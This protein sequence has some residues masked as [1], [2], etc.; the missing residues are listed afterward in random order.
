M[1]SAARITK[2][3]RRLMTTE[4]YLALPTDVERS[5]LIYG[6]VVVSPSAAWEHNVI[7]YYFRHILGC[8][9]RHFKLGQVC[10]DVDMVLDTVRHLIYQPDLVYLVAKHAARRDKGR[11]YGAADLCVEVQSPSDRPWIQNRKF[12]DYE[13]YGVSWYWIIR[14]DSELPSIEEHEL[15]DGKYIL[16]TEAIGDAWFKPA[17]FPGLELRLPPMIAGEELKAAVKGKAKRLV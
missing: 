3:K 2:P 4:E 10:F 6:E 8:W 7:I 13:S 16:R 14:P 5:E 15:V 1:I 17:L 12:A 9:A 11:V